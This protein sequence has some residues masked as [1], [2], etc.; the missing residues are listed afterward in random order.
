MEHVG[1]IVGKFVDVDLGVPL[2]DQG[3]RTLSLER[4]ALG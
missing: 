1:E 2:A 4:L 3:K